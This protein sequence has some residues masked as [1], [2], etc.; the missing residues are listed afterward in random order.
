MFERFTDRAR[1]VRAL[2]NHE[3][4]RLDHN[5]VGTE[6]LLLG[7]VKE[8]TGVGA[9]VLKNM[10]LNLEQVRA[11]VEK[12]SSAGAPPAAKGKLP[13]SPNAKKVLERAIQEARDL[14]HN[15]VGTEHLLLGLAAAPESTAGK[16]LGELGLNL[17]RV[18][19]EVRRLLGAG[20]VSGAMAAVARRKMKH[21][22]L[23]TEEGKEVKLTWPADLAEVVEAWPKLADPWRA[24]IVAIVHSAP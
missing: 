6:H 13:T 1:K 19:E 21:V 8:G 18:R 14:D 15:Y 16:V 7:L 4:Q 5:Y 12:C 22:T 20:G 11:E 17:E 2:A 3:A 10:G 23:S 9:N 24:A